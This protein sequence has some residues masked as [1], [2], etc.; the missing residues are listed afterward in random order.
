[1]DCTQYVFFFLP[2]IM[3]IVKMSGTISLLQEDLPASM[4]FQTSMA[5][6]ESTH[7]GA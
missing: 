3:V 1:M 6:A 7:V 4:D 5:R 2:D